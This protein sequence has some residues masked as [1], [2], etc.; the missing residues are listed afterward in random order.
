MKN[1]QQLANEI[2]KMLNESE[3]SFDQ[4]LKVIQLA[5]AKLIQWNNENKRKPERCDYEVGLK[6][7]FEYNNH[8][9]DYL[10]FLEKIVGI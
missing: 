6:G 8:M 3:L 4:Q 7:D 9:N 10:S 5:K 2:V 1:K